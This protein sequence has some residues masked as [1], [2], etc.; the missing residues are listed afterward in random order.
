MIT[1]DTQPAA[2][3]DG[4]QTTTD[5]SKGTF[6]RREF[7]AG[8]TVGGVTLLMPGFLRGRRREQRPSPSCTPT[9][10]TPASSAWA[11]LPTTPRSR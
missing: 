1:R 5:A 9:T 4:K 2:T 7:L 8:A 10:C 11:R 6:S 3:D